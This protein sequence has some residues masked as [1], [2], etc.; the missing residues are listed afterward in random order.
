MAG[1]WG[2]AEE[3]ELA[4]EKEEEINDRKHWRRG[5]RTEEVAQCSRSEERGEEGGKGASEARAREGG[6]AP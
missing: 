6:G 5:A 2:G 4:Q 3:Q 1:G